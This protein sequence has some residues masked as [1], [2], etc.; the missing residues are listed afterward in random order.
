MSIL[1][2][3]MPSHT[4]VSA[5]EETGLIDAGKGLC[6][7]FL[8]GWTCRT[9]DFVHVVSKLSGSYRVIVPD[10][11]ERALRRGGEV[12]F[13][14]ICADLVALLAELDVENPLLC[15]HSQ[16]GF[17]AAY[18]AKERSL[19]I[20][21]LLALETILP[22]TSELSASFLEWVPHLG[23]REAEAFWACTLNKALFAIQE[24]GPEM[25]SISAGMKAQPCNF[26]ADL[27]RA[28]C[29]DLDISLT[30]IRYNLPVHLLKVSVSEW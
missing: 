6:I 18:L 11:G 1:A 29:V 25:R 10:W 20:C 9:G 24:A 21:G 17:L 8:H 14:S 5:L 4:D 16:G 15:G 23:S 12:T 27:L 2:A 13:V 28:N 7:V 22:M 30:R 26:A 3:K 19:P